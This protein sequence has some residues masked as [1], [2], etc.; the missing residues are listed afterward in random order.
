[1]MWDS[2]LNQKSD[3]IRCIQVWNFVADELNLPMN[4]LNDFKQEIV[5]YYKTAI[6]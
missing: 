1:M 4:A 6:K 5:E 3:I 2:I